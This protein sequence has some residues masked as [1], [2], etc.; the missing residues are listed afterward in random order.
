MINKSMDVI[1]KFTGKRP[2]GWLG[3]GL[4]QTLRNARL[5]AD[6]GVKY[7]GDW[8]Y[9]DEPTVIKTANGPLVTLPYTVELNDIPMMIVQHHEAAY[10][11]R[12]AACDYFDRL[13]QEGADA[14]AR[15]WRLRS[16]PTFRASRIGSN[17]SKQVYE[18]I[19][20]HPGV[21]HWNGEEI[22]DWYNG[23]KKVHPMSGYVLPPP[24]VAS[25]P[26]I[27]T[28]A[29]FPVRRIYC[30]GRN[31]LDARARDERGRRRARSA[32]LLPE[33]GGRHRPRRRRL[34][35][36]DRDEIDCTTRSN[37]SSRSRRAAP[38]SRKP[39]RSIM[40]SAMASAS[41]LRAAI[42]RRSR[43]DKGWPWEMGKSFDHSA[44]LGAI[45]PGDVVGH[46]R[47]RGDHASTSMARNAS[48]R[49]SRI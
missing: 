26:V 30:V 8:V 6:A 21:V 3:P 42:C 15:S 39:K 37:S 10:W 11:S 14:P 7:I 19:N 40:S 29:R 47:T 18:H 43:K 2:I 4:T 33:A 12:R 41:T 31:Y 32:V 20:S 48:P 24:P 1:E 9:D 46:R 25:L 35:L 13:Y 49:P 45:A 27:G 22:Y 44:P 17:I 23:Q 28:D 36:P 34:A 38:T 16:I 5:L